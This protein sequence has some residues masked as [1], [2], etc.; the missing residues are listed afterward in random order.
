VRV[1]RQRARAHLDRVRRGRAGGWRGRLRACAVVV[2]AWVAGL[3]FG[4]GLAARL[5]GLPERPLEWIA[6]RGASHLTPLAVASATGVAPG[7]ALGQLE[8]EAVARSLAQH[9]WIASAQAL[10]LPGGTL[11]LD[12]VEREP[13]ARVAIDQAV[14]AVDR[15]G[16]PFAQLSGPDQ[17]GLPEI[18]ALDELA[19]GE[20]DPRLAQAVRLARRLPELGLAP[21][22]QVEVAAE[23][24]ERGY[25]LRLA[26]PDTRVVLGREDLAERLD[27][28]ARLLALRPDDV[29]GAAEI[30][31]RFAGQLVL[32]SEPT[33]DGSAATAPGRGRSP[34]PGGR[35]TG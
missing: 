25:A 27:G 1:R 2:S 29:A 30:D 11:V 15:E 13:V 21:P 14:Y 31:V 3:V 22:R 4:E 10:R 33:R 19:P 20:P 12:V 23:G 18:V 34:V 8:P 17:R 28:F 26:T 24:D 16:R 9:E 5:T 7:S 35:P 6:V 32:R